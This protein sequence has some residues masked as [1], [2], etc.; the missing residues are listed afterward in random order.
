MDVAQRRKPYQMHIYL[1][2][3]MQDA[4]KQSAAKRRGW[5]AQT[6]AEAAI[7]EWLVRDGFTPPASDSSESPPA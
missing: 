4:L 7:E 2:A 5:S 1:P 3:W 6:V